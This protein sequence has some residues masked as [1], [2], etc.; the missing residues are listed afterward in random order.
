MPDFSSITEEYDKSLMECQGVNPISRVVR[1]TVLNVSPFTTTIQ[2]SLI[3]NVNYTK[4]ESRN[5]L[6]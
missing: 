2:L 1:L 6:R 5:S 4:K 3:E